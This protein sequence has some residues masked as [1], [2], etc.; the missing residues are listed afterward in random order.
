M[1]PDKIDSFSVNRKVLRQ[2]YQGICSMRT[3]K[4]SVMIRLHE[5]RRLSREVPGAT[6]SATAEIMSDS[7]VAID[8]ELGREK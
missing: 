7:N 8:V 4:A 6:Q 5:N 2:G 1:C 3:G